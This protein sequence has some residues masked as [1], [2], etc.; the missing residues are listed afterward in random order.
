[1]TLQRLR[2]LRIAIL[3]GYLFALLGAAAGIG[4][5]LKGDASL[6]L[7]AVPLWALVI[8]FAYDWV[9]LTGQERQAAQ[10]L[11]EG[12]T[13][14]DLDSTIKLRGHSVIDQDSEWGLLV[15]TSGRGWEPLAAV[16]VT[17][18]T[19]EPDG[20]FKKYWLRVPA[21]GDRQPSRH[22]LVCERDIGFPPRTAK[23]A[24]AWTFTLCEAHYAIEK[25]T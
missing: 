4:Y 6:A 15:E 5:I 23:E 19:P 8:S 7:V 10:P 18:A 16:Q 1:M 14:E 11:R 2:A 24:I 13:Q 3:I 20:T 12:M 21:R 9:M 22:C 25:A 17:N